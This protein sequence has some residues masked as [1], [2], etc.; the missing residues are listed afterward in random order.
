M[1]N[2]QIQEKLYAFNE[3]CAEAHQIRNELKVIE[4][5]EQNRVENE[6]LKEQEKRRNR[7]LA[8]HLVEIE[9]LKLKNQANKNKLIIK[10]EH[11][12]IKLDKEIKLHN[13]DITR[14]QNL[15]TRLAVTIGRSRD[16][17]R[18]TKENARNL[19]RFLKSVKSSKSTRALNEAT[20][21]GSQVNKPTLRGTMSVTNYSIG[22]K[23]NIKINTATLTKFGI[24]SDAAT[25]RPINVQPGYMNSASFSA[26]TGKLLQQSRKEKNSLPSLAALYNQKLEPIENLE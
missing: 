22:Q 8:R 26:K 7:L 10:Y 11:E 18:R 2:L 4:I 25:D 19:Q 3:R 23:T 20:G 17:L 16:E 24:K 6:I 13:H 21:T 14:N 1:R 9:Q 12:K 15:A 5:D